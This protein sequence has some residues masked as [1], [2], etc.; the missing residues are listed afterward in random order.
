LVHYPQ[1]SKKSELFTHRKITTIIPNRILD[2]EILKSAITTNNIDIV[3]EII[4]IESINREKFDQLFN[5][6]I[7]K[8]LKL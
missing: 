4:T 2:N 8:L 3:D 6:A 1:F 5:P 7:N